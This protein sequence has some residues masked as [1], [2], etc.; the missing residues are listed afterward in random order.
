MVTIATPNWAPKRLELLHELVPMRCSHALTL[1]IGG[2]PHGGLLSDF[3]EEEG[4][5]CGRRSMSGAK[6]GHSEKC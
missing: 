3:Q 6:N 5:W 1:Q 4:K 2:L